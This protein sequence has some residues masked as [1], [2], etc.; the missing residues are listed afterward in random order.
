MAIDGP[1]QVKGCAGDLD[2]TLE[3]LG[4]DQDGCKNLT[5]AENKKYTKWIKGLLSI[6]IWLRSLQKS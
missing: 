2:I 3:I 5:E 4:M 6:K 1:L